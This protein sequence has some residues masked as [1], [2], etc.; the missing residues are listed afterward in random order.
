[1]T[2]QKQKAALALTGA[3]AL[4][5]GA[6]ALGAQADDGAAVAAGGNPAAAFAHHGPGRAGGPFGFDGLADRLGVSQAKLRAALEDIRSDLPKPGALR[7]EFAKELATELGSTEAKVKAALERIRAK[8]EAEFKDRRDA[9]AEEL[10]KRLNLDVSKVKDAL[11]TPRG[12]RPRA[13]P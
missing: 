8:H 5:S 6:Y 3:V 2:S 10:A 12:F 9:L 13:R 1:M 11:E 4:A 7:D